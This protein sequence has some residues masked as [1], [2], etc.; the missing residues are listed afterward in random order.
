MHYS[1]TCAHSTPLSYSSQIPWKINCGINHTGERKKKKWW[2]KSPERKKEG[3]L[4]TGREIGDGRWEGKKGRRTNKERKWLKRKCV[5]EKAKERGGG[6][7]RG[8]GNKPGT[9]FVHKHLKD[10]WRWEDCK[11]QKDRWHLFF[12]ASEILWRTAG[13][14]S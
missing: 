10:L 9:H 6:V 3:T 11:Y 1:C 2:W 14:G 8:E 13:R 12:N 7:W 4:S 5:W